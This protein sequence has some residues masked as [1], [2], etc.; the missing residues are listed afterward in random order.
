MK[1]K[2][3]P[4]PALMSPYLEK[5]LNEFI[6]VSKITPSHK[7][8]P[9]SSSASFLPSSCTEQILFGP[10]LGDGSLT[11]RWWCTDMLGKRGVLVVLVRVYSDCTEKCGVFPMTREQK[12]CEVTF[13]FFWEKC[14]V[15]IA[16]LQTKIDLIMFISCFTTSNQ[17]A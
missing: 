16:I 6:N 5:R 12:G 14:G 10:V 7:K 2:W 11:N 9:S 8:A 4:L 17:M 15:L 3:Q 13:F 1:P